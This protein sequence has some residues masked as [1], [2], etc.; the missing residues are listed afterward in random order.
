V[1][2]QWL[3]HKAKASWVARA[4]EGIPSLSTIDWEKKHC[5]L[6]VQSQGMRFSVARLTLPWAC[7][8]AL[9]DLN[10]QRKM[11]L[12][13]VLQADL[14]AHFPKN[15][16]PGVCPHN[17]VKLFVGSW[18]INPREPALPIPGAYI[19]LLLSLHELNIGKLKQEFEEGSPWPGDWK[20]VTEWPGQR[21]PW[22]SQ[23]TIGSPSKW[24]RPLENSLEGLRQETPSW[25]EVLVWQI[26]QG[27][28]NLQSTFVGW[29]LCQQASGHSG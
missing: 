2:V 7:I 14:A 28:H 18:T 9:R 19:S 27:P 8:T 1:I 12:I 17:A 15:K 11:D 13:G 16:S 6:L 20:A 26:P 24:N 10:W 23:H 29:H 25:L 4:W 3:L 5:S 21:V 22:I